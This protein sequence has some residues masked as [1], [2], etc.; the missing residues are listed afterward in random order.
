M[1]NPNLSRAERERLEYDSQDIWE[2]SHA[3]HMRGQHVFICPNTL[4]HERIYDELTARYASGKAALDIGC[5]FGVSSKKLL[6]LGARYV[7]GIDISQKAIAQALPSAIPNR[8]EF[9]CTDINAAIEGRYDLIYGRAILHHLDYPGLVTR[10]YENNLS[11]GG[12]M[13]FMEPLGDNLVSFLY[14]KLIRAHTQEERPFK[15]KDLQ[16][17]RKNFDLVDIYPFNYFSYPCGIL[18]SVMCRS[19][20]NLMLRICDRM[21]TWLAA[22]IRFL[23][24][25]FRQAI[26]VVRKSP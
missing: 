16:W 13:V 3:W 18:S 17:F 11:P 7:R 21:D 5:G 8:L 19:A 26:I 23:E 6:D 9:V 22:R 25:R 15:R 10:L 1:D 20:D 4:R 14:R 2:R 12:A 24:S